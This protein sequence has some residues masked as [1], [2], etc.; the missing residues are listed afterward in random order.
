MTR[1]DRR[2]FL[3]LFAAI[4]ALITL[5]GALA[6]PLQAQTTPAVLVSNLGQTGISGGSA[7]NEDF[8]A[9]QAFSV[10]SGGGDY[11]LTSIEIRTTSNVIFDGEIDSLSVSVWSADSSGHPASSLHTL[12]NPAS[13]TEDVAASFTAPAGATLQAGTTYVLVVHF[14]VDVNISQSP[15]WHSTES[16]DEDATSVTGWTIA[17]VG[18]WREATDTSWSSHTTSIHGIRVNGTAG[19]GTLPPASTDATLTDLVVSDGSSDLTLTPTFASDKYAYTAMVV[20]AVDEVTVTPTKNDSGASIDY[21]DGSNMTLADDDTSTDGQQV[22]LAEGDN[23]IKVKVTA[24]DGNATQTYTVTV[25]RAACT[26]NT[27]DLWCG[28]FTVEAV[29]DSGTTIGYGFLGTGALSDTEFSVGTNDYTIDAAWTGLN[30]LADQLFFG[31]SRGNLTTADKAKL[32]LQVDG[33]SDPFAFSDAGGPTPNGTYNWASTGLDWSS[34][35]EV[36][37]RL[38]D[39]PADTTAPTLTNAR[40]GLDGTRLELNFSED[41]DLP[42]GGVSLRRLKTPSR[43]PSTVWS[44]RSEG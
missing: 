44:K 35:S 17:D 14:D 31:L 6:L 37:L 28:V 19:T 24:A 23:V 26:L 7:L 41:L 20:K 32:V 15:R 13:I 22:T 39:T 42:A 4:A 34:T 3:V 11:T 8:L 40:V 18:L 38:R 10:P 9:A 25:N 16:G 27:G 2:R 43:S 33:H 29:E 12:T 36:T 21:L 5:S 30:T 1:T